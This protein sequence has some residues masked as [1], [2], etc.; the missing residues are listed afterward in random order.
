MGCPFRQNR[1]IIAASIPST[2]G[3]IVCNAPMKRVITCLLIAV[4]LYFLMPFVIKFIPQYRLAVWSISAGIVS[5][6][7][8][9]LMD[10]V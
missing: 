1:T 9:A 6:A 2:T 4:V 8:T 3:L 5:F 7:V 10:R